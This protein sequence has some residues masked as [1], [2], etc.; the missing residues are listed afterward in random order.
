M[1]T[2]KTLPSMDIISGLKGWVDF[3]LWMGIPVARRWPR[4][5]GPR[6]APQVEAQWS[7]FSYIAK[8][9]STLP[10]YMQEPYRKLAAGSGL[11]GR[12]MFSRAYLTGLYRYPTG[13]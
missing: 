11:V 13:P 9:W 12:D 7:A 2:L 6:R 3:Y 5:P 8:L 10:E 4:S 1:A